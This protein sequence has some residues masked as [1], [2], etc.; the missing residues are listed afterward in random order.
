MSA[1]DLNRRRNAL[2]YIIAHWGAA[3]V[4]VTLPL[5]LDS[6]TNQRVNWR[7]KAEKAETHRNA[8]ALALSGK[9]RGIR[10][11]KDRLAVLITRIAPSR[12]D[13][14]NAAAACKSVRDQVAAC[15]LVDDGDERV[16]WETDQERAGVREYACR[17]EIWRMT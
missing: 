7:R 16:A 6:L 3:D 10:A 12:L 11:H 5:R 17:V 15:L 14:D 4:S 9:V 8:V 2:A 1:T 13:S